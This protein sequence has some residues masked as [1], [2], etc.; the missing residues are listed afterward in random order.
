MSYAIFLLKYSY[1]SSDERL[2]LKETKEHALSHG[3][4]SLTDEG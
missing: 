1:A 4:G 2:S 3:A